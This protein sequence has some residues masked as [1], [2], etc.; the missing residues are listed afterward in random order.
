MEEIKNRLAQIGNC[1]I[2]IISKDE[3]QDAEFVI[4]E[5]DDYMKSAAIL[6]KTGE[7]FHLK[8]WQGGH[9]ANIDEIV[10]FNWVNEEGRDAIILGGLPRIL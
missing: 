7:L 2:E 5:F 9:P 4:F 3:I 8:D 1:D 10:D 6:Y